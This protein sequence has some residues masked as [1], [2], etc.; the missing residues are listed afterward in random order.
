MCKIE[1]SNLEFLKL[2]TPN[3]M[4]NL[5]FDI[6]LLHMLNFMSWT[7]YSKLCGKFDI[8][9]KIEQA[10]ITVVGFG[11]VNLT[12]PLENAFSGYLSKSISNK[13]MCHLKYW[14]IIHIHPKL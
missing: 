2:V 12:F 13:Y 7:P 3:D 5:K 14:R 1:S 4:S 10:L 11:Y 9:L 6:S 8:S